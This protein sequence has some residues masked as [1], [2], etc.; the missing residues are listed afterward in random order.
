MRERREDGAV[1][2]A[3]VPSDAEKLSRLWAEFMQ[4]LA[5]IDPRFEPSDD[6]LTR[7]KNDF[8]GWLDS[9]SRALFVVDT[10]G[11]LVG[12]VSVERTY[13]PPIYEAVPEAL[14]REVFL[15]PAR[16]RRGYGR[17]LLAEARKWCEARGIQRLRVD[18]LTRNH[19]A[20]DFFVGEGAEPF[21]QTLYVTLTPP[22][23]KDA[24][25]GREPLGFS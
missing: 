6:A 11:S 1:I 2:R 9:E 23:Q 24:D 4:E 12:F 10:G 25:R 3:A 22:T 13:A 19:E 20:I 17:Q 16:R 5:S 7:W 14:I 8:R 15:A 18:A 21:S